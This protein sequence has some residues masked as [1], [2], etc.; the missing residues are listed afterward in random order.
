MCFAG[1]ALRLAPAGPP[2]FGSKAPRHEITDALPQF[3]QDP[4]GPVTLRDAA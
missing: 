2:G 1:S 3:E 4:T